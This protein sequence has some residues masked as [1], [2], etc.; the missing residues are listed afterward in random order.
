MTMIE[1]LNYFIN[2]QEEHLVCLGYD[3]R[4]ETNHEV[5]DLDWYEQQYDEAQ[6]RLEDLKQ[7]KTILENQQ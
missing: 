5:N 4:E 3:I 1:T 6:Q 7:I 2:D